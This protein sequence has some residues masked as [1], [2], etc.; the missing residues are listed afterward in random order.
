VDLPDGTLV[1][2]TG[3]DVRL[4][5]R[6]RFEVEEGTIIGTCSNVGMVIQEILQ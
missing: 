4:K 5:R 1:A 3:H 2:T 6:F